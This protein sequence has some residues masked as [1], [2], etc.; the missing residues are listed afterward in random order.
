MSAGYFISMYRD[1]RMI[2]HRCRQN[3]SLDDAF[4]PKIDDQNQPSKPKKV[5]Y[6]SLISKVAKKAQVSNPPTSPPQDH[7]STYSVQS[8]PSHY[9]S[10]PLYTQTAPAPKPQN[11]DF[12]NQHFSH[13]QHFYSHFEREN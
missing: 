6:E 5:Y 9:L 8:D 13:G 11:L 2:E 4:I 10:H 1:D 3:K 12:H 7:P